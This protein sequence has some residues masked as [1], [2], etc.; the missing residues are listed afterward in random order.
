MIQ[1]QKELLGAEENTLPT[2]TDAISAFIKSVRLR[3]VA[4]A[5]LWLSYLWQIPSERSRIQRRVLFESGE[6]NISVDVIEKV[7]D[8]FGSSSKKS[9]EAA[10]TEVLRICETPNWWA[11]P[12]GRQYIYAWHR[13]E[14]ESPNFRSL[15]LD[16]LFD[17][18]HTAIHGKN[19]IRGLGAFNAVYGRRDFRPKELANLMLA[20]S[21]ECGGQQAQRLARVFDRH[22]GTFWLD[23][24]VSGQT[25]YALIHGDFGDQTC[26][27]VSAES[28]EKMIGQ[29]AEQLKSGLAVPSY[30]RD[31]VHTRGGSDRRF[32]GVLKFMSGSCRA[33]EHFGRLIPEDEWLPE[34]MELPNT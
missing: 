18:M 4:D 12:E 15:G 11:Q 23:G 14:L 16:A 27:Q 10:V 21:E 3:R 17:E 20:W 19:L 8:W 2:P 24:N 22:V 31:G 29:A 33:Y 32:A 28:V 7:S 26:P 34:F 9:L 5:V 1:G 13:A 6:D 30:A 25:Y